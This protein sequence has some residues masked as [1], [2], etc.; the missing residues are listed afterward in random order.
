M[1]V[2]TFI[3][4]ITAVNDGGEEMASLFVFVRGF[5][6]TYTRNWQNQLWYLIGGVVYL[7]K[8]NNFIQR[9]LIDK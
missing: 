1:N 2:F 4:G 8:T 5:C 3:D 9:S 6:K 7:I